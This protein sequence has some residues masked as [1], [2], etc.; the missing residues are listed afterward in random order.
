MAPEPDEGGLTRDTLLDGRVALWQRRGG[1][2][3]GTDAVLLAA[4]TTLA[5]GELLVDAGAGT[6]AVGLMAG[7]RA[8]E[9]RIVL[10]ER[11]PALAALGVRNLAQ[12]GMS[13]RGISVCADLL[14]G[15]PLAPARADAVATNPPY[16]EPGEAPRSPDAARAAAHALAEGSLAAWI[17]ACARLLRPRG[18]LS[19]IQRADKLPA[20]LAALERR[21][22]AI[23]V[24][25]VR[26]R[27]D[28]DATRIV[29]HAVKDARTPLSIAPAFVLHEADGR[30]TARADRAHRE[31]VW[32]Q[33]TSERSG[34]QVGS[35]A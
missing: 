18:R 22:G 12:N 11:D 20:C 16:F 14:A 33:R 21:F 29:I 1:H 35:E 19:L 17:E 7:V 8:P 30:F 23:R 31:G 26:P 13:G 6:G 25:P 32:D 34:D 5:P 24:T 10:V 2:R 27:A 3:A 9:A 15:L 4:A 28:R